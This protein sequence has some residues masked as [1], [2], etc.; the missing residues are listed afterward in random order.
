[1]QYCDVLCISDFVSKMTLN[2]VITFCNYIVCRG[3]C[4]HRILYCRTSG[5]QDWHLLY[6]VVVTMTTKCMPA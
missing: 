4:L 5:K 1:M 2:L 6:M 3:G